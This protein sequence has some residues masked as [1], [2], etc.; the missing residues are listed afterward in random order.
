[1]NKNF[2]FF[3]LKFIVSAALIWF[4]ISNFELGSAVDRFDNINYLYIFGAVLIFAALLFNNTVRWMIVLNA[5][6]ADLSFGK[7]FKILWISYFFNQT[8]PS[9]IGGDAYKIY[10]VRKTGIELKSAITGVML[11]RA[12]AF[13]GLI[14]LVILGQPFLLAH[15]EDDPAKF[16]FPLLAVVS[17]FGIIALLLLDRLPKRLQAMT[18]IRG[19]LHLASDAKRLFLSPQHASKA[20][21][22]GISGNI[23]IAMLAYFT[24]CAL[25]VDV[26]IL[27]CL[28]LIPPVILFITLPI[29]IAGWG[30]R[31]GAMVG[32]FALVGVL[33]GDAFVVSVLFGLLNII[34]SLPGGLLWLLGDYNRAEVVNE[35]KH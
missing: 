8:L 29:S 11:E 15:I 22:L 28:V 14:F 23:L 34:F 3:P 30:V 7:A 12:V 4:L 32:A 1:M 2:L 26:S 6:Y 21:I 24:F 27:D 35:V 20:I 13:L 19:L 17:M 25:S 31:E 10:L 33:E 9:T 5:I 18:I 16:L